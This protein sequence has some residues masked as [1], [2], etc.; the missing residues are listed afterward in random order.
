MVVEKNNKKGLYNLDTRERL[1]PPI[2][3]EIKNINFYDFDG[4]NYR[5]VKINVLINGKQ[6]EKKIRLNS[7]GKMN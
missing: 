4:F 2:Y 3:D 1:L 7:Q 5:K 6:K